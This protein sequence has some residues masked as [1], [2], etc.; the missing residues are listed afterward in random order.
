MKRS[1]RAVWALA[2]VACGAVSVRAAGVA[3][4]GSLA[5]EPKFK[6][7]AAEEVRQKLFDWLAAR[8]ADEAVRQSA[9]TIWQIVQPPVDLLERVAKTLGLAD[10]R[11]ASLVNLCAKARAAGPLAPQEWLKADELAA[12]ERNN[13][14][15][16]YGRWLAQERM[17]DEAFAQLDGLGAGDVVDPASLVFYQAVVYHRL[18]DKARGLKAIQ[19]LLADVADV[20]NRYRSVAA[21]MKA[22]L[23]ALQDDSLDRI[24]RQMED[25]RRRLALGR[26]GKKVREVEDE[27]ITALD[28]LIKELEDRQ[29]QSQNSAGGGAAPQP[30]QAMPDSRIARLQAPGEVE[31]RR[32]GN[33]SGWG[34][35]PPKQREEALQQIGKDF[36]PHYRDAIEQYFR[37]L[38]AETEE[39]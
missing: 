15:L 31:R 22:D 27:V 39:R 5:A 13:L 26:A 1:S 38:A 14:R 9:E 18:L 16:F 4:L 19:T 30:Q 36:P 10:E 7:P 21:L 2:M 28:K 24:S 35:L 32:I 3:D 11:A 17:Y 23:E 25:V 8:Q 12:F 34:D 6:P 29:Q 37:K 33:S 20:P